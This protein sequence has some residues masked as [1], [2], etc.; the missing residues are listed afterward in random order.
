LTTFPEEAVAK[1]SKL[2]FGIPEFDAML[3]GG[4]RAG[5]L[6]ML[7][8]SSGSGKSLFGLQ[9]LADGIRHG[10]RAV[11]FGFYERPDAM[12]AK[13][14]RVGNGWIR[15]GVEQGS[16]VLLWRRP[17]EGIVDELGE[18]LIAAVRRNKA[19]RLVIDG[20]NG[21]ELAADFRERMSDV[22]TAIAQELEALGVT[23]LYTVEMRSLYGPRVDVP[24]NGLSAATQNIVLFR[25]VEHR[26]QLLRALAILKV[27]DSDYDPRVRELRFTDEGIRL[28]DTFE[29]ESQLIVGGGFAE[30]VDPDPR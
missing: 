26:A 22:Y 12:D 13:C 14:D 9:F 3:H 10:E 8:G 30:P 20:I 29:N 11:Y 7:V 1:G 4:V 15:K 24:I 28:L 23:T 17:V 21:F 25:H 19:T 18:S 5:S 16:A 6:T 2:A 27:R